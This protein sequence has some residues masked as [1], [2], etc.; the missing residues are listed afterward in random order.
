MLINNGMK[1]QSMAINIKLLEY[2]KHFLETGMECE[3]ICKTTI[4][5]KKHYYVWHLQWRR[6]IFVVNVTELSLNSK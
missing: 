4:L 1:K 2:M 3:E 6:E 5:V